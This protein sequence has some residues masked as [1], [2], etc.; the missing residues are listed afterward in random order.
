MTLFSC[1][2]DI[3]PF[4]QTAMCV[5]SLRSLWRDDEGSA[6][7]EGAIIVPFLLIL[8]L[9]VFE[10][11]WLIYQRH[12][13]S[14]GINDGA[15]YI[16]RSTNPRDLTTQNGAKN[17]ATTGAIDGDAARVRGWTTRD[18]HI[19]Y[20][21]FNNSV[22]SNGLTPFRGDTAI[23][24]VTVSTTVAVPSL[25]F[26]GF[27][28]LKPPALTISHQERIVGPSQVMRR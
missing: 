4:G 25:G 11:S 12:L 15:R 8:V 24:I 21:S 2:G 6:L 1:I 9:G 19:S 22:D 14:T 26:F 27:I 16:T 18:V 13:I 28:G 23:Q 10:F 5:R 3:P 17:L 20:T 7:I